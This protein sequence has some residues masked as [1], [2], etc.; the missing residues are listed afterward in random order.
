M[1][2]HQRNSACYMLRLDPVAVQFTP[3]FEKAYDEVDALMR[4]TGQIGIGNETVALILWT[5][6]REGVKILMPNEIEKA[7]ETAAPVVEKTAVEIE[8][9]RALDAEAQ[10]AK[11]VPE[12]RKPGRK[13]GARR[14]KRRKPA[15]KE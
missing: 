2:R 5:L 1:Q 3:E 4:G 7:E 8:S 15:L 11:A 10:E 12:K 6:Q 14:M 9:R 13:K